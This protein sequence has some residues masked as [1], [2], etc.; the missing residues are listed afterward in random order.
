M[1]PEFI[2]RP[3][4]DYLT[5]QNILVLDFETTNLDK[6]SA[7]N[8][9]NRLLVTVWEFNGVVHHNCN[10]EYEQNQLLKDIEMAD[11]VVA[12]NAKF[13]LQW[14]ARIGADISKILVFDTMLAE[15]VIRGNRRGKLDLG[16]L[17]SK[18][19]YGVKDPYIDR[20]MKDGICPSELPRSLL[21]ARCIKDVYQTK[22][23]YEKQLTELLR[24][25]KL[26]AFY[27][28]VILTPVLADIESNGICLDCERVEEEYRRQLE[29]ATTTKKQL[30]DLTGGINTRSTPQVAEYLYSTLGF[31]EL[32]DR[33][34][35]PIRGKETK[36]FPN[37][38]PKTDE[39]TILRLKITTQAQRKFIELKKVYSK[40]ASALSKYLEFF[41]GVCREKDGIFY[42]Q[43]NQAITQTH[44]LSSS[45]RP[46]QFSF[47]D[48]PKSVQFQN[49]QRA[50]KKFFKPK[51]KDYV[52]CEPDGAQ[53][54]F[55]VAGHLGRDKQ[56][57]QDII[58]GIDVHSFTSKTITDAGQET[59]RQEAKA[60]TF[61][62]LYGGQSGTKAEQAYYAA[63]KQKY[64]GIASAQEVWKASVLNDKEKGLVTET[65]LVFYWPGTKYEGSYLINQEAICNY[66]VQSLATAD[67]IPIA[68]TKLWH[69]LKD[70]GLKSIIVNTIHDSSPM[71]IYRP[72][73]DLVEP[74][75][76]ESY[77]EYVY[78][79]LK[80]V[81][82]IDFLAPLGVGIKIGD[83]WGEGAE[84]KLQ[85]NPPTKLEGVNYKEE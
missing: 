60:H 78:Y 76:I 41:I 3:N 85:V 73:I 48:K 35:K 62:P 59:D 43:F 19:G 79:Y 52:F 66:P 81:Y 30:D 5:S 45:G 18:Y 32:T 67:I 42:G 9:D 44:R 58:D 49:L 46:I 39:S 56:I 83:H 69:E 84:K 15:Y 70:R 10:S 27:T 16:S 55:R 4:P 75:I 50:Y 63:F 72:E 25:S 65:G 8:P 29:I 82:D 61:K 12:H 80:E 7:L 40:A 26:A 64:N 11:V 31:A 54:E 74:I 14:L 6:G 38:M 51:D 17:A 57:I 21:E 33:Q 20:C 28:R 36:R 23:I 77:T 2:L 1:I 47:Y 68:I 22:G 71:E 53:L 37:G 34:G 13:E 24:T